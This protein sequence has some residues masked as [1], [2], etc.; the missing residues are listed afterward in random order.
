MD[1]YDINESK[2]Y[3][4]QE[5]Y[6]NY[7]L[8]RNS[9]YQE[10][11]V[12]KKKR[13]IFPYIVIALLFSL[14]GGMTGSYIVLNYAGSLKKDVNISQGMYLSYPTFRGNDE[15]LSVTETVA[16]VAPAVVGVT[17][18]SSIDYGYS[19]DYQEGIGTGFIINEEGYILTNYHVIQNVTEVN[20]IFFSG[21]DAEA[22]IVNYDEDQD[23]ALLKLV[24]T[25]KVPGVVELGDSSHLQVGEEVIAIGNPL[26]IEFLGTVTTGVI[27]AL[28]REIS[29]EGRSIEY[30]QTDAAIN[31]GNSGGPL[32]N[33]RGQVIGINT[34]KIRMEGVEGI[35]FS[36]PINNAKDRLEALAKPQLLLGISA[37]DINDEI[38]VRSNLPE[39]EY[40]LVVEVIKNSPAEE[41]G[42]LPG[43]R[44]ISFDGNRIKT[45]DDI[46][47]LKDKYNS[48]D[49]VILTI[50]RDN[51]EQTLEVILKEK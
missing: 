21:E 36:I 42:I 23:L 27:S 51:K 44:I 32:V 4:E 2:E 17:T 26:G 15:G 45:V 9:F 43:D 40:V 6:I 11:P 37:Q 5:D 33:S 14:F 8:Y 31:P 10:K 29:I 13:R 50:I 7:N 18:K 20:V 35:G 28:G 38:A 30:L 39:G 46:N 47:K 16:K 24:N 12:E 3:K 22:K 25:V 41:A 19:T 1:K 34:A 49:K 48:G